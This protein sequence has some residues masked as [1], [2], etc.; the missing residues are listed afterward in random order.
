MTTATTPFTYAEV[1]ATARTPL[2]AGYHHLR[3]TTRLG[4]GRAVFR[5]AAE[6]VLDWRMHRAMTGVRIPAGTPAVAPGVRVRPAIGFGPLRLSG[7][8]AVVRVVREETTAG[9]AYGTLPGH[10]ECGEE[11]FVV[12]IDEDGWVTLT[13][14]AFSRPARWFTR[15]AGPLVR[16][17]QRAYGRECGRALR[18]LVTRPA[19]PAPPAGA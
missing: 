4:R 11:A 7:E 13:V 5:T 6:A 19:P 15:A 8:C 9:F 14:L 2:P 18:G 12:A 1:G 17:V 10:P 3:V 16:I